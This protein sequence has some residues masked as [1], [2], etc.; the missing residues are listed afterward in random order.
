MSLIIHF[1]GLATFVAAV[2]TPPPSRPAHILVPRFADI[3]KKENIAA[4][5]WSSQ[6]G[7]TGYTDFFIE[8]KDITV[9]GGNPFSTDFQNGMPHLACCCQEMTP[10]EGGLSAQYNDPDERLQKKSAYVFL[11]HGVVGNECKDGICGPTRPVYL[12]WTIAPVNG[13]ITIT[14]KKNPNDPNPE[15][16]VINVPQNQNVDIQFLNVPTTGSHDSHFKHY[17]EMAQ[18]ANHCQATPKNNPATCGAQPTDCPFPTVSA[19]AKSAKTTAAKVSPAYARMMKGCR[20]CANADIDC[21]SS[22]WP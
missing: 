13:Q 15:T 6:P 11:D 5:H 8:M 16:I 2:T 22:A 20:T 19:A 4:S 10:A 1:I 18:T 9:S 7:P 14:G 21:S 3:I 17:Y 12:T